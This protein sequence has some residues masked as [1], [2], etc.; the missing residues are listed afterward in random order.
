MSIARTDRALIIASSTERGGDLASGFTNARILTPDE[1]PLG[2]EA[3]EGLDLII[4]DALPLSGSL[5]VGLGPVAAAGVPIAIPLI[6]EA[7][8]ACRREPQLLLGLRLAA[9]T[10][11]PNAVVGVLARTDLSLNGTY[12]PDLDAD[13]DV[14]EVLG[15]LA[16]ERVDLLQ[17]NRSLRQQLDAAQGAL[18]TANTRL[19]EL[20][21]KVRRL[22]ESR[23]RAERRWAALRTHSLGRLVLFGLRTRTWLRA[24]T[25]STQTRTRLITRAA[26]VLVGLIALVGLSVAIAALTNSGYRGALVSAA[27]LLLCAFATTTSMRVRQIQSTL[28]EQGT[29]RTTQHAALT[30]SVHTL[31]K[32]VEELDE[33]SR[34]AD[35]LAQ[36]SLNLVTVTNVDLAN[37]VRRRHETA[38][39]AAS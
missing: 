23:N 20:A 7:A 16:L 27:L 19:D 37:A 38:A 35:A 29:R 8:A 9:V 21:V 28:L 10:R 30:K 11:I 13:F 22:R 31:R 15:E 6:G 36:H 17:E 26:L 4:V 1:P 39:D 14:T 3:A 24:R 12:L 18:L 33:Q 34:A 32:A 2:S 25:V 5:L